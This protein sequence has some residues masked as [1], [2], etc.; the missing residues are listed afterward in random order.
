MASEPLEKVNLLKKFIVDF[1]RSQHIP[2]ALELL[3]VARAA[4]ADEKLRTGDAEGGVTLFKLA[5]MEAPD[6]IP[7]K[8]FTEIIAK[9][10]YS[11]YWNGQRPAAMEIASAIEARVSTSASQLVS[12]ANFFASIEHGAEAQRLAE[13]ALKADPATSPAYQTIGLA[14]RLNFY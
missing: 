12:L 7:E 13:A 3:V 5:V 9:F 1:P 8:L 11:L 4:V 6:P 2:R 10:P 14:H